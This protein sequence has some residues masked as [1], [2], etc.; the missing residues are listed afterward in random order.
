MNIKK[1]QQQWDE[2]PLTLILGLAIV[3]R[4]L[5]VLFSKG[6]GMLDDHFLVIEASQS[7]IDGQ[8]YNNWLPKSGATDP[9]GHNFF[10]VGIHYILFYIMEFLGLSS[11][12]GKMYIIRLIHAAFSLLTI[13]F[14]YKIT[15]KLSNINSARQVGLLLALLWFMPFMSVRNMVEVV[16]MPFLLWGILLLL[17]Q[18]DRDGR[19]DKRE[20]K[21]DERGKRNE[22]LWNYV[23]A[24]LLFGIAFSV[25]YQTLLFTGGVG[26]VLLFNRKFFGTILLAG[27]FVISVFLTQAIVDI[28]IW[29]YPFA[30]LIAYI[31]HNITYRTDYIVL[32][33][34]NYI[35]LILGIL[36]PP[37]SFFLFFGFF[38][39]VLKRERLII[40]IPTL[41][42][43]VFHSIYPNKQERFILPVIPFFILLG[44]IGWNEY[45]KDSSFWQQRKKLLFGCWIFFWILNLTL[46]PVIS[47]TYSKRARVEAMTYLS[48]Y[49]NI[50]FVLFENSNKYG[51]M[52]FPRYY[53]DEWINYTE[54]TLDNVNEPFPED[55][56]TNPY[57]LPRFFVFAEEKN[58]DKRVRN[59][60]R[61]Y[62]NMVYETTIEPGVID[63][64]MQWLNPIN[65]NETITIYRNTTVIPAMKNE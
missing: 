26:L 12:Q 65:A 52:L 11:P 63:K 6:Y 20:K 4:L 32:P 30:E 60:Q 49:E 22:E 36:I 47:T 24:G 38:K 34:Y 16:C 2:N 8:D 23:W 40:F 46:L 17:P 21:K 9:Q 41:I 3:F 13:Y 45:I 19:Q 55:L 58:L 50:R 29:G 7:W 48:R 42:F 15:E 59:I 14:G 64:V 61:H 25:R 35:L 62:P 27:A 54:I 43:L 56:K 10:Y 57:I 51:Q 33:W 37:I 1:I 18:Q 44:I 53:I 28:F 39:T 31:D 5:A